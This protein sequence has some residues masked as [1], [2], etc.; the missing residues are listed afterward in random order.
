LKTTCHFEVPRRGAYGLRERHT[1]ELL[2]DQELVSGDLALQTG[3][4]T[5][6]IKARL[7]SFERQLRAAAV[8][9]SR[10]RHLPVKIVFVNVPEEGLDEL[11][12]DSL[13]PCATIEIGRLPQPDAAETRKDDP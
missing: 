9:L 6:T 12:L 13:D 3:I 7:D 11:R 2:D 8:T 4:G 10:A 1:S 5:V